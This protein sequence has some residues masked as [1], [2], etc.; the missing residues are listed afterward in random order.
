MD[1]GRTIPVQGRLRQAHLFRRRTQLHSDFFAIVSQVKGWRVKGDRTNLSFDVD[2]LIAAC[3]NEKTRVI[4]QPSFHFEFAEFEEFTGK[5]DKLRAAGL[6][7][8]FIPVSIV[9][10]PDRE[11][12]QNFREKFRQR[13]TTRRSTASR[14]LTKENFPTPRLTVLVASRTRRRFCIPVASSR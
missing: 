6:L 3:R 14:V 12:G 10:L 9:N 1:R 13:V 8:N 4:V 11:E 5:M 2:K 7:S